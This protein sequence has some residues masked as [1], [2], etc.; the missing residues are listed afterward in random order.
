MANTMFG[1]MSGVRPVNW[2]IL[3]HKFVGK[4]LPHMG[5]KP[6]FLSPYILHLYQHYDCF[7]AEEED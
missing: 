1:A 7:T 6:S 5:R 2:G 4:S 3:I